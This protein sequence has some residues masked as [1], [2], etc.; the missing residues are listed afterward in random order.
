M[1]DEKE[2]KQKETSKTLNKG[3]QQLGTKYLLLR[4]EN[5][6]LKEKI[7]ILEGSIEYR[8]NP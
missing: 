4:A 1:N 2:N 5:D 6:F 7:T 3:Y 8:N